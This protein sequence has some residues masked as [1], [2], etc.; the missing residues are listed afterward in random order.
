MTETAR[1]RKG[2]EQPGNPWTRRKGS[3]LTNLHLRLQVGSCG[4]FLLSVFHI[5]ST[6][7]KHIL[8]ICHEFRRVEYVGKE[9]KAC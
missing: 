4:Y 9:E 8:Y 2:S 6:F 1:S 7:I 5:I 3:D